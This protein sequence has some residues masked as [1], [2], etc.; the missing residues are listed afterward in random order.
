M[1]HDEDFLDDVIDGIWM[2]PEA[3]NGRPYEIEVLPVQSF[4]WRHF[5]RWKD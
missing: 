1:D 4:E 5:G 3:P 2:D